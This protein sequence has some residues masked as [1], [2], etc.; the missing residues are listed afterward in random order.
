MSDK[1]IDCKEKV[2]KLLDEL[3][4][5]REEFVQKL[6]E[7]IEALNERIRLLIEER[8]RVQGEIR[9][10]KVLKG[11]APNINGEILKEFADEDTT[12]KDVKKAQLLK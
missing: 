1:K 10:L 12:T 7:E 2:T 11:Q 9:L 8:T 3:K 5:Q 6:N 4:K